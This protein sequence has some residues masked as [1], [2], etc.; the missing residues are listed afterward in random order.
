VRIF[1]DESGTFGR[2]K[3][4]PSISV[5]GALILPDYRWHRI[6]GKYGELR[7]KLP[8]VNGEVKGRLLSERHIADVVSLLRSNDALFFAAA[9]DLAQQSEAEVKTHQ[10]GQARGITNSL[11]P[12]HQPSMRNHLGE[13][14]SSLEALTPQ[15][16][17]QSTLM[18]DLIHR[19]LRDAT[20]YFCQRQPKELAGFHWEIDAKDKGIT[21]WEQWWTKVVLPILQS[22]SESDPWP[23]LSAPDGDYSFMKRFEVPVPAWARRPPRDREPANF[24]QVAWNTRLILMEDFRFESDAT[25]GLELVDILVNAVRRAL[26]G[27]LQPEGF[28]SIPSLMVDRRQCLHL[29]TLSKANIRR[30]KAPYDQIILEHF[31]KG[32]RSILL[33]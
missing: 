5:V 24:Q 1:I 19:A 7:T 12:R 26:N 4:G 2:A 23:Q 3:T 33:P 16:Y 22:K 25:P 10:M 27:H 31:K 9:I 15:L 30:A 11:T 18:F 28:A 14:R 20:L 13:L 29:L 8:Q 17:V 6:Q 32:G 21:K